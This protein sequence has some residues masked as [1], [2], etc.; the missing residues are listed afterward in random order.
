MWSL[1]ECHLAIIFACAPSLRAFFRRYLGETFKRTFRSGSASK[2]RTKN[3]SQNNS[4]V[5]QS[6][7]LSDVEAAKS[8]AIFDQ[9]VLEKPSDETMEAHNETWSKR[10]QSSFTITTADDYDMYT[11]R[12]LNKHG[13]TMSAASDGTAHYWS[14]PTRKHD[15]DN[16]VCYTHLCCSQ[17]RFLF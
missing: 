2:D 13:H 6:Y 14:D 11:M 15:V 4:T 17:L 3:S 16:A 12:Q 1:L 9:R 10:S 5:R 7:A 8:K